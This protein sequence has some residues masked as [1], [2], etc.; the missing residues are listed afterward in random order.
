[1]TVALVPNG[2]VLFA[3]LQRCSFL[4]QLCQLRT[5]LL[6]L[7]VMLKLKMLQLFAHIDQ[8]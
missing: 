2:G 1:M 7:V 8:E 6:D 3:L 5:F 4:V